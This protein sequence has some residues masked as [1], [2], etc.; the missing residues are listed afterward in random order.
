MDHF[1]IV[2]GRLL[3]GGFE[4][5]S[6]FGCLPLVND[7]LMGICYNGSCVDDH[8]RKCGH[9]CLL[10]LHKGSGIQMMNWKDKSTC[11]YS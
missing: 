6:G 4:G 1:S 10:L 9:H 8:G 2:Q 11:L 3:N 7:L 5:G